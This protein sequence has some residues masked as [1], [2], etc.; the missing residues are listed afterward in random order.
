MVRLE[1]HLK[2]AGT[3][4]YT[5]SNKGLESLCRRNPADL[6]L[7]CVHI[8][9]HR[10]LYQVAC[11]HEVDLGLVPILLCG[12]MTATQALLQTFTLRG[13]NEK[14]RGNVLF[15]SQLQQR[16]LTTRMLNWVSPVPDAQL[17]KGD[18]SVHSKPHL[19]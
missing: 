9:I 18:H 12:K 14:H 2:A 11:T 8:N 16:I 7:V 13:S 1:T 6:K 17:R 19:T 15:L 5:F 4:K 10:L 3:E